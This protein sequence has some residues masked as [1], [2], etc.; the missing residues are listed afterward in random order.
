MAKQGTNKF[1]V[2]PKIVA[3]G[4]GDK[5]GYH[6]NVAFDDFEIDDVFGCA[7][8]RIGDNVITVDHKTL[9]QLI[10]VLQSMDQEL[11]YA[12]Q[13]SKYDT[14]FQQEEHF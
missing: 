13:P 12:A 9:G 2:E 11:Y 4:V 14:E 8:F 7:T 6:Y 1:N 3:H 5:D 10:S